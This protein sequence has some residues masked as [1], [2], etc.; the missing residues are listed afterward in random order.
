MAVSSGSINRG[1]QKDQQANEA[2]GK[3]RGGLSTK[4]HASV[5]ALG[6]PVRFI[7]MQGQSSEY[8]PA[9]PLIEGFKAD[10]VLA[11]KNYGANR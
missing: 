6:N 5:D 10:V 8:D 1:R 9:A 4:I 7:V 2:E 3:S 11:D